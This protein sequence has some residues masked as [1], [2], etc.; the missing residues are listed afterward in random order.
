MKA[1]SIRIGIVWS[2]VCY[3][4]SYASAQPKTFPL[5]LERT[6]FYVGDTIRVVGE[7]DSLAFLYSNMGGCNPGPYFT[8]TTVPDSQMIMGNIICGYLLVEYQFT[9]PLQIEFRLFEPGIYQVN[10]FSWRRNELD[11]ASAT[12]HH[13]VFNF[14]VASQPFTVLPKPE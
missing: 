10:A 2:C 8:V 11:Q 5:S 9:A 6:E 12:D 13:F 4:V 7:A 14:P 3:W 1:A